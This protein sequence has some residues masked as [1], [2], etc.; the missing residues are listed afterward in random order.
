MVPM[1]PELFLFNSDNI[2]SGIDTLYHE[3][4]KVG[5]FKYGSD[6]DRLKQPCYGLKTCAFRNLEED[7]LTNAQI[8]LVNGMKLLNKY[9]TDRLQGVDDNQNKDLLISA[10]YTFMQTN[11]LASLIFSYRGKLSERQSQARRELRRLHDLFVVEMLGGVVEDYD[12]PDEIFIK[13]MMKEV[14]Q[15]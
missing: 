11:A 8:L 7:D 6:P 13:R 15:G 5:K 12:A 1:L 14:C 3:L 4:A 10:V 2:C 9:K